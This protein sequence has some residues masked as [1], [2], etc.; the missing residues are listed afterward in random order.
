MALS[1]FFKSVDKCIA[2]TRSPFMFLQWKE[3]VAGDNRLSV[4]YKNQAVVAL[5]H[6][7]SYLCRDWGIRDRLQVL[8]T[9]YARL[10]RLPRVWSDR[11]LDHQSIAICEVALKSGGA[12]LLSLEPSEFGKEGEMGFYLRAADGERMYSMNFTF[13]P[14]DRVLIGGLQGPRPTV[15]EGTLRV[16]GK[17]MFGMRPKNLLL[18]AL[19]AFSELAGCKQLLGVTDMA[20]VCSDRLKSSYDL[21]WQEAQGAPLDRCWYRLP[22][23][24]PVRDIAEVKSQ[25]RGEFRRREALRE[26]LVQDI[27]AAWSS[28]VAEAGAMV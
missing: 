25:R 27:R 20:H 9:H 26:T 28:A 10:E 22:D 16:L 11:L 8:S 24:E 14:G 4:P 17:E 23:T 18:T 13:A 1:N 15:E 6:R 5:R 21:F 3:R 2:M 7:K 19:Y 12:L